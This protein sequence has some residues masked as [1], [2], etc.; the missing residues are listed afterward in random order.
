MCIQ[1]RGGHSEQHE[2]S[3]RCRS[4]LTGYFS[5]V[6]GLAALLYSQ[7]VLDSACCS[8]HCLRPIPT[9]SLGDFVLLSYAGVI[10]IAS[11]IALFSLSS[12]VLAVQWTGTQQN[13][14]VVQPQRS[15]AFLG[16]TL[17]LV[18]RTS[19]ILGIDQGPKLTGRRSKGLCRTRYPLA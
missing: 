1:I 10:L 12:I 13:C 3:I 2:K 4:E 7:V 9:M 15:P 17:G 19:L 11:G 14:N 8:G 5:V 6:A 18:S 16:F